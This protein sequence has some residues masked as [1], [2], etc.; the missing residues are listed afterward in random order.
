[1]FTTMG[2]S[3]L[4]PPIFLTQPDIPKEAVIVFLF[5]EL[6]PGA[7]DQ[8]YQYLLKNSEI[9]NAEV[10]KILRTDDTI[11]AYK[12]ISNWVKLGLLVVSNP[13]VAKQNR[14]YR[15]PGVTPDQ[16]LLSKLLG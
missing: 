11:K 6:R 10:R 7:W 15:L 14:R 12:A 4:Y 1:M 13:T 5:N 3:D 2:Q 16:G 9:G 8:V